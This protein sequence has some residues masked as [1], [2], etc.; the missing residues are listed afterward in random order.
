M[1]A[2][3]LTGH[4][5]NVFEASCS[6]EA[7]RIAADPESHGSIF[8]SSDLVLP[9]DN[10]LQLAEQLGRQHNSLKVLLITGY[11]ERAVR[12][13]H[14][15]DPELPLLTKPFTMRDFTKTVRKILDGDAPHRQDQRSVD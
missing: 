6:E 15:L 2:G 10:G 12:R 9:T 14:A 4:G 1:L 13:K 11:A 3:F 5:Y 8:L 7:L